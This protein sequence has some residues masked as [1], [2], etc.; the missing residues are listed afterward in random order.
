MKNHIAQLGISS[1]QRL[2][3]WVTSG[4]EDNELVLNTMAFLHDENRGVIIVEG[5]IEGD[6]I[7]GLEYAVPDFQAMVH[8]VLADVPINHIDEEKAVALRAY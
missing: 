6:E 2:K 7:D 3:E 8:E 1:K 4:M 5:L